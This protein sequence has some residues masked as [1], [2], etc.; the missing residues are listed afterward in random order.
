MRQTETLAKA[1]LKDGAAQTGVR[2]RRDKD[3]DTRDLE[4][5]LA[6]AL[7]LGVELR[8]KNGKGELRLKYGSLEQLD[9]VC[10]KLMR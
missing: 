9:E 3:P 10:A 8:D 5:S 1:A 6:N 7:G 2:R 4:T